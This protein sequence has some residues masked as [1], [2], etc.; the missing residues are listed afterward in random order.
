MSFALRARRRRGTRSGSSQ[1]GAHQAL[2]AAAAAAWPS[3]SACRSPTVAA[4][5][6]RRAARVAL[7]DGGARARRRRHRHQRRLQRQP[8]LD[9]GRARRRCAAIGRRRA[10]RTVAVLGEMRELG[11]ASTTPS[12]DG[13]GGSAR[14]A[15]RRRRSSWSARRPR[16]IADGA[17]ERRRLGRRSRSS[18][19]GVDEALAW[20]RENVAPGRRRAG[21]GLAG[22]GAWN[23]SPTALL[24]DGPTECRREGGR[25]DESDPARRWHS[26]C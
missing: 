7:A 16:P 26:R 18:R 9:A 19:R 4:A 12:T 5:P 25:R 1:V 10:G 2:N 13:V 3:R 8:R 17:R 21:E 23:T 20:L 14:A 22:G 6:D 24:D 15:R 11:D